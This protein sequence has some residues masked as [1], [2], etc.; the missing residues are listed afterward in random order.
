M[1][2]RK[3][4]KEVRFACGTDSLQP[5]PWRPLLTLSQP[6]KAIEE[7]EESVAQALFDLEATNAGAQSSRQRAPDVLR[8][9][10]DTPDGRANAFTLLACGAALPPLR[11]L[12]S[13]A[14]C[15]ACGPRDPQEG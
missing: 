10:L 11:A 5:R 7:F 12:R 4:V 14:Q 6:G 8:G 13:G 15:A 2:R 9:W 3:C 1:A